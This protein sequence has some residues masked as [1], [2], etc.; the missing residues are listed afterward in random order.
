MVLSKVS[1]VLTLGLIEWRRDKTIQNERV[2]L[3]AYSEFLGVK[4]NTLVSWMNNEHEPSFEAMV[5]LAY[6]LLPYLGERAFDHLGLDRPNIQF[7]ELRA[8]Y[9]ATPEEKRQEMLDLI[10]SWMAENHFWREK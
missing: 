6:K 3:R 2:S 5:K 1:E 8:K 7:K 10:E 4:H 9:D